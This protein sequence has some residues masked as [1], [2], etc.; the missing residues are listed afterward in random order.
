MFD[1]VCAPSRPFSSGCSRRRRGCGPVGC[2][3]AL[4]PGC[5]RS[6]PGP[7]PSRPACGC[8]PALP[9]ESYATGRRRCHPEARS[10][11]RDGAVRMRALRTG[12]ARGL[13]EMPLLRLSGAADDDCALC[14]W[15]CLCAYRC[16][17][18]PGQRVGS[19]PR[20]GTR[21][22]GRPCTSSADPASRACRSMTARRGPG[23]LRSARKARRA[24]PGP[25]GRP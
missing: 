14:Y 2:A 6:R 22:S 12:Q 4:R 13:A 5:C 7:H 25:S 24:R 1:E 20:G 10:R 3:A 9:K 19:I 21:L 11:S 18:Y 16:K 17:C 8:L 15:C 23:N